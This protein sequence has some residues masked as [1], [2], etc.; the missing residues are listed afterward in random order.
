VYS[1]STCLCLAKNYLK[2]GYFTG[3]VELWGEL[4]KPSMCTG[5][6]GRGLSS[7]PMQGQGWAKVFHR[8]VECCCYPYPLL[9]PPRSS[10]LE[11][12]P[13]V[14]FGCFAFALLAQGYIVICTFQSHERSGS[15][16]VM[17]CSRKL[18]LHPRHTGPRPNR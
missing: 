10:L 9:K 12:L 7:S 13:Q 5:T 14:S 6:T 2:S 8:A 17:L 15:S 1:W 16:E 4:I 3:L 11:R 18:S